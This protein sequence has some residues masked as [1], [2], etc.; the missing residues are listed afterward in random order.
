LKQLKIGLQSDFFIWDFF[1]LDSFWNNWFW[2]P[3]LALAG[4]T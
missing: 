4:G 1:V 3:A 2:N